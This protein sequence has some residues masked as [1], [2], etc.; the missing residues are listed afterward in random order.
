[1]RA[2]FGRIVRRPF[3]E[4]RE[5]PFVSVSLIGGGAILAGLGVV[6]HSAAA[7]LGFPLIVLGIWRMPGG[8]EVKLPVAVAF[9]IAFALILSGALG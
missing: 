2:S 4:P 1:M 9:A 7:L 5:R 8:R 3:A 6:G